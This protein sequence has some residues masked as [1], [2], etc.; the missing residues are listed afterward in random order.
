MQNYRKVGILTLVALM[1]LGLMVMW[2]SDFLLKQGGY[3]MI[4]SFQD[5]QGLTIG[6]DVRYRGVKAGKVMK[7]D[8]GMDDIRVYSLIN[9]GIRL[10]ANSFLRVAFDG[11]VGVKYLEVIPVHSVGI[12]QPSQVLSGETTSGIVDFVDIASQNLEE[13]KKI[14]EV[15]RAIIERPDIQAAFIDAVLTTQKAANQ[16][17]ELTIELQKIAR[18]IDNVVSDQKF[19][20]SVKGVAGQTDKTLTSANEF[21]ASFA[22]LRL[23][24][25]GNVQ[26][27]TLN[28]EIR[29]NID[30]V[31]GKNRH[32]YYRFGIGEGPA[33]TQGLS[34]QDLWIARQ[35]SS[36]FGMRIGMINAALGGGVEFFPNDLTNLSADLYKIN[37]NPD[38]PKMRLT[39]EQQIEDYLDVVIRADDILNY[40]KNYSIGLTVKSK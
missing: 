26:F 35:V 11:L 13:T 30:I 5:I 32:D 34:L 10:P 3:Q 36:R 19:Q 7:I 12:Y 17:N 1:M 28:N 24:P 16:I 39:A 29:A 33:T 31:P 15:I 14:L 4:G 6:S 27:G 21:F 2:K 9:R 8:P 40:N 20:A 23:V 38:Y 37:N 18:S 22:N 25:S